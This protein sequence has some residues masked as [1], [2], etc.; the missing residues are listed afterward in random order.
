[1]NEPT[2]QDFMSMVATER[3]T[4]GIIWGSVGFIVGIMVAWLV[5][6]IQKD[7]AN[8]ALKHNGG[9]DNENVQ[10]TPF[11]IRAR[12]TTAG[13]YDNRPESSGSKS[14]GSRSSSQR[15]HSSDGPGVASGG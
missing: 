7:L 3:I 13:E 11:A 12:A 14:P 15:P 8:R 2:M 10:A 1:M 6:E 5:I 4:I 9:G